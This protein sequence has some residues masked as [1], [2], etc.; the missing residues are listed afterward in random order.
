[1]GVVAST[2]GVGELIA[3]AAGGGAAAAAEGGGALAA[4]AIGGEVGSGAVV[5]A[6]V[7]G[8]GAFG[9]EGSGAFLGADAVQAEVV[10]SENAVKAEATE[11]AGLVADEDASV[12]KAAAKA[13]IV[14]L[15]ANHLATASPYFVSAFLYLVLSSARMSQF[16]LWTPAHKDA[17][18]PITHL[19]LVLSSE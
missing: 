4:G 7:E 1:M 5:A 12:S 2:V 16:H 18:H 3:S 14:F 19:A 10:Q 6:T 11:E 13:P 9:A 17:S 8:A 15:Q